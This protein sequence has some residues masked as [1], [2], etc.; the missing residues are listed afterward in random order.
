MSGRVRR[1][2][3]RTGWRTIALVCVLS[4]AGCAFAT[5]DGWDRTE[6]DGLE[7]AHPKGWV[8]VGD[9][10]LTERWVWGVQDAP[11]DA[12]A[13]QLLAT[14]R[15]GTDRYADMATAGIVAN[16]QLSLPGFRIEDVS[17]VDVTGASS[18]QQTSFS[19]D[20][21]DGMRYEGVWV[22]AADRSAGHSAAVQFSGSGLDPDF[23]RDVVAGLKLMP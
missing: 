2:D 21:D 8:A 23:V 14:G 11:G 4:L 6:L 19:Y 17:D 5:A 10:T 3:W 16:A 22:V 13:L 1:R 18:A 9:E 7:V 12:A 15:L 20:S